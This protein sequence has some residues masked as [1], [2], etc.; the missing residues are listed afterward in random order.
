M[1][2]P[3]STFEVIAQE[4]QVKSEYYVK[5]SPSKCVSN[6]H[7]IQ[8]QIKQ[9]ESNK[10][11][12]LLYNQYKQRLVS[13]KMYGP[14][15]AAERQLKDGIIHR[16]HGNNLISNSMWLIQKRQR[17]IK[18]CPLIVSLKIYF[19]CFY[20]FNEIVMDPQMVC[21][22]IF[23]LSGYAPVSGKEYTFNQ[24][25]PNESIFLSKIISKFTKKYIS[26]DQLSISTTLAA[27]NE[28]Q[29]YFQDDV[30]RFISKRLPHYT[31]NIFNNVNNPIFDRRNALNVILVEDIK[32]FS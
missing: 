12:G 10:Y 1:T 9:I 16:S 3:G 13:N 4:R 15:L 18:R 11:F 8:L 17:D 22:F 29:R 5:L 20:F 19:Y 28:D 14:C 21:I 2:F 6:F 32:L 26:D 24:S 31:H 27:S 25:I 23:L 30:S 7:L